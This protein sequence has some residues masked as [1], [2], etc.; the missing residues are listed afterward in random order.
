MPYFWPGRK[1]YYYV[2]GCYRSIYSKLRHPCRSPWTVPSKELQLASTALINILIDP[3]EYYRPHSHT[4]T[5]SYYFHKHFSWCIDEED[6]DNS[7]KINEGIKDLWGWAYSRWGCYWLRTALFDQMEGSA[8]RFWYLGTIVRI[9]TYS[10]V[11]LILAE[12]ETNRG[13]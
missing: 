2:L 5:S 7:V 11:S 9:A 1:A 10:R 3:Q 4:L 13:S 8:P 12:Q 6:V